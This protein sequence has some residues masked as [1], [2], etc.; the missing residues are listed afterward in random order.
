L[1]DREIPATPEQSAFRL[2]QTDTVL[3]EALPSD[4]CEILMSQAN[5]DL[6]KEI[7]DIRNNVLKA[8][9]QPT[10]EL[11]QRAERMLGT[12]LII[13][14]S[15][16]QAKQ[17]LQEV[18]SMPNFVADTP[19]REID[20]PAQIPVEQETPLSKD[21]YA[22]YT[23]EGPKWQRLYAA[24][25]LA[26]VLPI[27]AFALWKYVSASSVGRIAGN[28]VNTD[29]R[30]GMTTQ[31]NSE[32]PAG[33]LVFIMVPTSGVQLKLD[34]KIF[35]ST[36]ESLDVTPGIHELE[37][38]AKGYSTVNMTLAAESGSRTVV[39]LLMKPVPAAVE[40]KPQSLPPPPA[41]VAA[42]Q[43]SNPR[44][45]TTGNIRWNPGLVEVDIYENDRH[46]GSTPMTLD[47]PAGAHTFEYRHEGLKKTITLNVQ[48][49]STTTTVVTFEITVTINAKPFANVFL[50]GDS[51]V[52]LGET[53]LNKVTVPVGGALA[54]QYSNLPEKVYRISAKDANGSIYMN[55][56]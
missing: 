20:E 19:K 24:L 11:L 17:L 44:P 38:S 21:A 4:G 26:L 51:R 39:P 15:H 49:E 41:L 3:P 28:A 55:F 7:N 14:P 27:S 54:F 12:I 52:P 18:R 42:N 47:L 46:L 10:L 2:R 16:E 30:A 37:F 5:P 9:Q 22:G 53:P 13:D 25:A 33:K 50:V 6:Q 36:P 23:R 45:V 1:S 48:P 8:E 32:K 40:I 43:Q 29:P 35:G 34:G 56:P 31:S